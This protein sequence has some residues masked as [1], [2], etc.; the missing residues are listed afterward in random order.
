M[1]FNWE[2]ALAE[3]QPLM[4][5]GETLKKRDLAAAYRNQAYDL[6]M[7]GHPKLT[8]VY[9][10]EG[11]RLRAI[12]AIREKLIQEFSGNSMLTPLEW[13]EYFDEVM[14]AS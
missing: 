8:T 3:F 10:T 4:P 14:K 5:N 12:P 13:F 6:R 1:E 2:T 9:D 7:A 11:E